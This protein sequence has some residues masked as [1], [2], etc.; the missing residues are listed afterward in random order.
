M[1]I[2]FI[3]PSS[4][5]KS[6]A[7][8]I[9]KKYFNSENIKIAKPLYDLQAYF[10]DFIGKSIGETQDGELLQFFGIKIRKENPSFLLDS[11]YQRV[12]SSTNEIITNDDCRPPD[13]IYLKELGFIFIKINGYRRD[14]DDYVKA[15][16]KSKVEWQDDLPCDYE[17]DNTGA[18]EDYEKNILKLLKE[19]INNEKMLHNTEGNLFL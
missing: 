10:Y 18:I 8:G 7:V 13:Y 5:G 6:T 1:K 19:I 17:L 4:Y 15:D 12:S 3:A 9:I 11:F 14:R 2:C 16:E